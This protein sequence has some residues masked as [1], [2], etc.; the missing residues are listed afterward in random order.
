MASHGYPWPDML[1]CEKLP[2]DNDLCIGVQTNRSSTQESA[3]GQASC[4]IC[5]NITSVRDLAMDNF[6]RAEFVAKIKPE[7]VVI[8]G[9]DLK[10]MSAKK[11][12]F[13]KNPTSA[14][15]NKRR[16]TFYVQ[17]GAKCDCF[18]LS[19]SGQYIVMGRVKDKQRMTLTSVV[20]YDPRSKAGKQMLRAMKNSDGCSAAANNGRRKIRRRIAIKQGKK[21]NERKNVG[22]QFRKVG[23]KGTKKQ[24]ERQKI[25]SSRNRNSKRIG[26]TAF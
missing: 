21:R 17:D 11:V 3:N 20:K 6:C 25:D 2:S 24:K 14:V 23:N 18:D 9:N 12:K 7:M 4:K 15:S 1:D 8:S 10:I 5:E 19:N 22:M 16:H 13:Y 26:K